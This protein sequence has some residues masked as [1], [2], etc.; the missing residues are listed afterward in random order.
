VVFR[1]PHPD[2]VIPSVPLTEYVLGAIEDHRDHPALVD[3]MTGRT[4]TFGELA[5]GIR[6]L[7]AG[8]SQRGIGKGDVV[9]IWS[10]NLPEYAIVFHAVSRI[11][12]VL[13]TANPVYTAEELAF[14]LGDAGARLLV[15]TGALLERARAAVAATGCDITIVTI[16]E[17][18]GVPSLSAV[19]VDADPPPVVIDPATDVVVMP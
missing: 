19:A 4:I 5:A 17:A 12:A 18:D 16:D 15:T 9:A 10:P 3:G 2:V 8:L 14:Q 6:R 11:G 7:A 1:S 13:T